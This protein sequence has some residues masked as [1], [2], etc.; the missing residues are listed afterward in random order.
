MR[1]L[2]LAAVLLC[3]LVF[4][5]AITTADA[6]P[7]LG[8]PRPVNAKPGYKGPENGKIKCL[9]GDKGCKGHSHM[10]YDHLIGKRYME[11]VSKEDAATGNFIS[12]ADLPGSHRVVFPGQAVTKDLRLDRLNVHVNP[13]GVVQRL[14]FG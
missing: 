7:S 11:L 9:A 6:F 1:V 12:K 10:D 2:T 3:V 8:K 14:S 4:M 5:S 13:E